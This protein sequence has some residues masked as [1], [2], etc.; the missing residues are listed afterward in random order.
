MKVGLT[1]AIKLLLEVEQITETKALKAVIDL[2]DDSHGTKP[3][4]ELITRAELVPKGT[5]PDWYNA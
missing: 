5:R 3:D 4:H 2:H 1:D